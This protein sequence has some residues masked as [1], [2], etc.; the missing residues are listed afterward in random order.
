MNRAVKVRLNRSGFTLRGGS[1]SRLTPAD[2]RWS[3]VQMH[4]AIRYIRGCRAV[5]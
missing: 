4:Y 5:S 1:I 3:A 2:A